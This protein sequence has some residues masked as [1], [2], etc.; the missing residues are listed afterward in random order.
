MYAGCRRC[1]LFIFFLL[2][3]KGREC[4]RLELSSSGDGAAIR[5][6]EEL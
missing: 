1:D 4:D 3:L 2:G 5:G 6:C